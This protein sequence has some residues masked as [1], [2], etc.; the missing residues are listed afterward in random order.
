MRLNQLRRKHFIADA[1]RRLN[2][3][4]KKPTLRSP[5]E[6]FPSPE[7]CSAVAETK[8]AIQAEPLP[9]EGTRREMEA[10]SQLGD[11]VVGAELL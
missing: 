4:E 8:A 2:E 5:E 7:I 1:V 6:F 11:Q 10:W 3:M 9:S